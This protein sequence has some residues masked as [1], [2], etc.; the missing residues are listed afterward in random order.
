MLF[1]DGRLQ[2]RHQLLGACLVHALVLLGYGGVDTINMISNVLVDP[3]Q[4]LFQLFRAETDRT[5]DPDA[6]GLADRHDHV[7]A[8]GER[9][10][11]CLDPKLFTEFGLHALPPDTG[12][13]PRLH[14]V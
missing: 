11:R 9:E 12:I 7:A 2:H 5:E 8:V 10:D 1:G 6:P 14:E 13:S 4:L 3:V